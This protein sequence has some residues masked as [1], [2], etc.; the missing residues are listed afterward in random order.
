MLY[1]FNIA[2]RVDLK[3]TYHKIEI[4]RERGREAESLES[5]RYIYIFTGIDCSDGVRYI[6]ISKH[7]KLYTLNT[8]SFFYVNHTSIKR[9]FFLERFEKK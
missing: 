6:L 1:T 7:T 4:C 5:K 9:F 3:C 2:K 8:Y